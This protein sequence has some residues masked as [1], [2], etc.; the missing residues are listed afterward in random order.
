MAITPRNIEIVSD[1]GKYT[2]KA[3]LIAEADSYS[4]DNWL[5]TKTYTGS[6]WTAS[7]MENGKPIKGIQV[8]D[9]NYQPYISI[10]TI[11][12]H[13]IKLSKNT[14]LY[15]AYA[16]RMFTK[17]LENIDCKK[18]ERKYYTEYLQA[19]RTDGTL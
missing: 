4:Q 9:G 19:R 8:K 11:C 1:N 17:A 13:G 12:C 10:N 5:P 18:V 3:K 14:I 2:I 6:H 7:I 16:T 15:L